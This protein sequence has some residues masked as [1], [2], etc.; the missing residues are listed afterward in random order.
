MRHAN[1]IG[2]IFPMP[3]G[4]TADHGLHPHHPLTQHYLDVAVPDALQSRRPLKWARSLLHTYSSTSRPKMPCLRK[5]SAIA[6]RF[7]QDKRVLDAP[8][9][10]RKRVVNALD[11]HLEIFDP[12]DGPIQ[13][14]R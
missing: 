6:R 7:F 11:H 13:V 9:Q 14:A 10:T 1:A 12:V 4:C 8:A 2:D 3:C 5:A